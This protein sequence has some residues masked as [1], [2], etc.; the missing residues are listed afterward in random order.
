MSMCFQIRPRLREYVNQ[1]NEFCNSCKATFLLITTNVCKFNLYHE[2]AM[3]N[4]W[5]S[6]LT[7]F[8]SQEHVHDP[9]IFLSTVKLF[10]RCTTTKFRHCY[11][12]F[13]LSST[14]SRIYTPFARVSVQSI[15]RATLNELFFIAD[16]VAKKIYVRFARDWRLMG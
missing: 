15:T 6:T 12:F 11:N 1:F 14:S 2:N 16:L 9:D 10:F 7:K 4:I 5:K 8:F 13:S 3:R